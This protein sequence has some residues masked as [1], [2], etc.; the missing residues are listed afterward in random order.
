MILRRVLACAAAAAI[1]AFGQPSFAAV[2]NPPSAP[3]DLTVV[4][5]TGSTIVMAH[6]GVFVGVK[7]LATSQQPIGNF[8]CF[9]NATVP[10]G[11]IIFNASQIAPGQY[12]PELAP[13][14]R[15]SNGVVCTTAITIT[16][17][18]LGILTRAQ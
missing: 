7:N 6:A 4:T 15:V 14:T 8:T 5:A 11:K 2:S 10:S 18:G 1:L 17:P 3:N 16:T 12:L 13:G 9:D